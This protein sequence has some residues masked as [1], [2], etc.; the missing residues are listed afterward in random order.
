MTNNSG[1]VRKLGANSMMKATKVTV[2]SPTAKD[3]R[4][5]KKQLFTNSANARKASV[6]VTRNNL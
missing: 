1:S 5:I 4:D 2:T 3:L 6:D